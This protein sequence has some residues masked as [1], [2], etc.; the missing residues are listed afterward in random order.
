MKKI[1]IVASVAVAVLASVG[2]F[3]SMNIDNSELSELQMENIEAMTY[4][5]P[6]VTVTCSSGT[7]GRCFSNF[8]GRWCMCGE[9][10]YQE[11][12]FT[13]YQYDSCYRP[14]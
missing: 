11:C 13:G 6:E 5:L 1:K 10:M 3:M 4:E 14:C 8:M 2:A 12:H 9:Y 7:Q